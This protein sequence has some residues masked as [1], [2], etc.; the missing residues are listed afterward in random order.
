MGLADIIAAYIG[1]AVLQNDGFL[2]LQRIDVAQQFG[3]AP[4]QINYVLSTRFTPEH[5][6]CVMSRRGGGGYIRITRISVDRDALIMHTVNAIGQS[7]DASTAMALLQNLHS[8]LP[9]NICALMIAA[10]DDVALRTV[11]LPLRDCVRASILKRILT[12]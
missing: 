1:T 10:V 12:R 11:P 9:D 2:E 3:C 6:Y 8:V 7:V 5:G 4:S